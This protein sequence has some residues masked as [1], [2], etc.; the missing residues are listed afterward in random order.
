MPPLLLM[1]M[2]AVTVDLILEDVRNGEWM[3]SAAR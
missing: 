1:S 2:L 3:N